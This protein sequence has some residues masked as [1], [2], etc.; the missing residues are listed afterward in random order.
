MPRIRVNGVELHY[1][2]HGP[3]DAPVVV[4]SNGVLA[5]TAGWFNQT[6]VLSKGFRVLLYDCRGQGRSEHPAG[7]YSME[8]HA[9]DLA[10]LLTALEV[11]KAH[12]GGISYGGEISLLFAAKYPDRTKSVIA[13]SAVSEV[14]PLLRAQ[15]ELW[16]AAAQA[17]DPLLFFRATV[18]HNFSAAFIASN[19]AFLESSISRFAALD[20]DAVLALFDAFQRLNITAELERIKAPTLLLY[21]SEDALKPPSVY[22]RIIAD[23]IPHAEFL[24]IPGAGHVII[25]E[26]PDAVNSALLGFLAKWKQV[27]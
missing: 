23:K 1:E 14:L 19:Q 16:T 12:I 8:M 26:K 15:I 21:G 17:H 9:D 2:W 25:W 11:E 7:P 18:T 6:P 27:E 5:N 24:T 22:G 10:E 13:M 3:E 20:I 4:L